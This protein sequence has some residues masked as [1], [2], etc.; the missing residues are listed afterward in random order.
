MTIYILILA[1]GF[2]QM[3]VLWYWLHSVKLELKKNIQL[4]AILCEQNMEKEIEK[5][6]KSFVK[7]IS[8][9][10]GGE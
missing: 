4:L 5:T 7:K 2:A 6:G 10:I 3:A 9:L 8:C 1:V